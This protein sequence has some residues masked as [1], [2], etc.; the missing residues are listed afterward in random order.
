M[1]YRYNFCE[2]GAYHLNSK[3]EPE[4]TRLPQVQPL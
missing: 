2:Y 3:D 1:P 4:N